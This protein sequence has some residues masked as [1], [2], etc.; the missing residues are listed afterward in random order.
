MI[1][2][3]VTQKFLWDFEIQADHLIS[4]RRPNLMIGNKKRG[5]L[6]NRGRCP[7]SRLQSKIKRNRRDKN[8]DL[9]R[10]LKKR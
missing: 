4:A 1:I 7:P 9:V 6:P 3:I 5:S 10:E 2:I 8:L